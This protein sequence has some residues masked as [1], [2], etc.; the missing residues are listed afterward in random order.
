VS[1]LAER[2]WLST[3]LSPSQGQGRN[4]GPLDFLLVPVLYFLGA[5]AGVALTVMPEGVAI[6]WPPNAIFLA[7]LLR[8]RGRGYVWFV[9]LIILAEIAADYPRF[10]VL[11]GVIFGVINIAEVTLAYALL[12]LWNFDARLRAPSDI[13]KFA[14]AG[15]LV[16][17][18]AASWLG[19]WT[20]T[21][22]RGGA[23]TYFE[24]LRI[25]WFGDAVG[26]M[27]VTPALLSLWVEPDAHDEPW[28]RRRSD[29]VVALAAVATI[30]VLFAAHGGML[31]GIRIG[32]L[33]LVPLV[34][35][36]AWRYGL[37]ATAIAAA[38]AATTTIVLVTMDRQPFGN[39]DPREEVLLAQEFI[40]ITS[41]MGLGLAALTRQLRQRHTEVAAAHA[42]V[43][44]LNA[45][46][47][48]RVQERTADLEQ[49]LAQVKRLQGLLPMCAWCKKV[50]DDD[51]YWHSVEDYISQRT[52]ARFSHGICPECSSRVLRDVHGDDPESSG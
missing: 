51:H 13:L 32:P 5:K 40:L 9:P 4:P 30:G 33:V 22:F 43:A 23:T 48:L 45:G 26:L 50:R 44:A 19:A 21:A 24:F 41:V 15:P 6:L 7:A 34:L 47:E 17:A 14:L 28:R 29:F 8:F 46:L 38:V 36:V 39:E 31:W 1:S 3:S 27:I 18:F 20:Y 10:T 35:A 2:W 12:R 25:W 49:A 37:T 42:E 52:D 16:A 11:E